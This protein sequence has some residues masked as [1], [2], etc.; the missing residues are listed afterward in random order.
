MDKWEAKNDGFGVVRKEMSAY[1]LKEDMIINRL[2]WMSRV[3]VVNPKYLNKVF[4]IVVV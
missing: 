2:E 4:V 3:H 1:D